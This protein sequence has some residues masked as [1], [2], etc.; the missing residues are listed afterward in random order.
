M[1]TNN[2]IISFFLGAIGGQFAI[3]ALYFHNVYFAIVA[4]IIALCWFYNLY[5][6]EKKATEH[7][8]VEKNVAQKVK[9]LKRQLEI[10][11]ANI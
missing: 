6:V 1:Y 2:Y 7:E 5:V 3:Y 8:K 9:I 4:C 11:K 10:E